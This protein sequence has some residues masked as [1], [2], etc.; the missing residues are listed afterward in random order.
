MNAK[1]GIKVS[2]EYDGVQYSL[3]IIEIIK[4]KNYSWIGELGNVGEV[5]FAVHGDLENG[6][7]MM[8]NLKVQYDGFGIHGYM[9]DVSFEC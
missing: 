9:D 4:Y 8:K 7:P 1:K 6:I 5:Y 2:F 3:P